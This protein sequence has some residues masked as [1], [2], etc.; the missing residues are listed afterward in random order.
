MG[1]SSTI[2]HT[3]EAG[4][5][6]GQFDIEI[7]PQTILYLNLGFSSHSLCDLRQVT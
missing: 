4:G 3:K 6:G 7:E 5:C 2:K 1:Y